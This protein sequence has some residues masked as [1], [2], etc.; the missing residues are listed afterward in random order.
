MQYDSI[1]ALRRNYHTPSTTSDRRFW[2]ILQ[3][4]KKYLRYND[5]LLE[6]N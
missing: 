3:I 5:V 1:V 4:K 2:P 6:Q